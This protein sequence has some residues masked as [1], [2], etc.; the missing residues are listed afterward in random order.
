[1]EPEPPPL[2]P[3]AGSSYTISKNKTVSEQ[4][5]TAENR[6]IEPE[7]Q[8]FTEKPSVQNQNRNRE[9]R[10][11]FG[12]DSRFFGTSGSRTLGMSTHIAFK[13]KI[14]TSETILHFFPQFY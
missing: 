2:E 12:T 3:W 5:K 14:Y 11:R 9:I 7:P 6:K 13:T 1:M 8:K 10:S 4:Q